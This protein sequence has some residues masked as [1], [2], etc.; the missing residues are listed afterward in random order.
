LKEDGLQYSYIVD[1]DLSPS[2]KTYEKFFCIQILREYD[3]PCYHV[4]DTTDSPPSL[5]IIPYSTTIVGIFSQS[6]E[7]HFH[8]TDAQSRK[9]EKIFK[10]LK[11]PATLH[12]YPPKF[13]EYLPLFFGE[14]HIVAE[15]HLGDFQNVIENLEIMHEDVVM[16]LFSKSLVGD[17][18]LWFKN[19]EV[20]SIGSWDEL[21]CKIPDI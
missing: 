20:G 7:P 9:R 8:P 16:R 12:P 18:A 14:D 13:L 21:F 4:N 17:A 15:N 19:V 11:L 10:S 1:V 2:S 5:I 6:I 3:H